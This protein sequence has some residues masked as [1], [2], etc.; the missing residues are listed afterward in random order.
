VRVI[1]PDPA[2]AVVGVM[3]VTVGDV[4]AGGGVPTGFD[5][6]PPQPERRANAKREK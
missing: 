4:D 1:G 5:E 2:A 6:D 3:E